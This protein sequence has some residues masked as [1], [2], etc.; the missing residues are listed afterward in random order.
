MGK[1]NAEDTY[2][3]DHLLVP[4]EQ[5]DTQSKW[6]TLWAMR[7]LKRLNKTCMSGGMYIDSN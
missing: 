4:V 6:I 7:V 2:N 3:N 1:W 5:K